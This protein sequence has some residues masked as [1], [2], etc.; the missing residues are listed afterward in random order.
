MTFTPHGGMFMTTRRHYRSIS[1]YDDDITKRDFLPTMAT[2][3][4]VER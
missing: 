3:T 2:D 1:P 4:Q